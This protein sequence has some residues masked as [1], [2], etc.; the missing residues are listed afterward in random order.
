MLLNRM[1]KSKT[2]I[3]TGGG[4]EEDYKYIKEQIRKH[5][6][7][8]YMKTY[9]EKL[10]KLYSVT[11]KLI[12]IEI[13]FYDEPADALIQGEYY[14]A[15]DDT[16]TTN[17][18]FDKRTITI[19]KNKHKEY[20]EKL[21]STINKTRIHI[22]LKKPEEENNIS[23]VIGNIDIILDN[24]DIILSR[25]SNQPKNSW[26]EELERIRIYLIKARVVYSTDTDFKDIYT[27]EKEKEEKRIADSINIYSQNL[28]IEKEKQEERM[29]QNNISGTFQNG[30][31]KN[32]DDYPNNPTIGGSPKIKKANKKDVL[33][34][35]RCIYKISGDRKEYVKYKGNLMTLKDYKNIMKKKK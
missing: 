22:R 6:Y 32:M 28:Q 35:E 19:N 7:I 29:L 9:L 13:E 4:D 10:D 17:I 25:H 34:K 1:V 26:I 20:C 14:K 11:N 3:Y 5:T 15:Y 27:V 30:Q 33:G 12:D 16:E 8:F 24:I 23:K 21:A 18:G 31:V 2:V